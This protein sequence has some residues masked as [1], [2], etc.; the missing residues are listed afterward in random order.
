MQNLYSESYK[1]ALLLT[2]LS[3]FV[4]YGGIY[5]DS[6]Q[7]NS[8]QPLIDWPVKLTIFYQLYQVVLSC[9]IER[10]LAILIFN[11]RI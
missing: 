7:T 8:V 3:H 11:I 10:I 5:C 6:S 2:G 1:R 4:M 9:F